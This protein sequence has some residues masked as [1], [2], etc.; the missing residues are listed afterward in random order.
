MIHRTLTCLRKARITIPQLSP[1][2]TKAKI[3]K[4]CLPNGVDAATTTGLKVKDYDPLLVLRCS[5]DLIAE[6]YRESDSHQPYMIVEVQ[7]EGLLKINETVELDKWYPVGHTIGE[8]DDGDQDV[9][10]DGNWVW[11]AYSYNNNDDDSCKN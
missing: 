1:T 7:E 4:W 9:D 8:I 11:Q 3:S 10:Y 6:G 5:A 2:H